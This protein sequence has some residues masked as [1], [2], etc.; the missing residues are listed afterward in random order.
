[1]CDGNFLISPHSGNPSA[2]KLSGEMFRWN[3]KSSDPFSQSLSSLLEINFKLVHQTSCAPRK[4]Q[5]NFSKSHFRRKETILSPFIIINEP[6]IATMVDISWEPSENLFN[7]RSPVSC[8]WMLRKQSRNKSTE[9]SLMFPDERNI[10]AE[11]SSFSSQLLALHL[12]D[13]L[14]ALA[15]FSPFTTSSL[16]ISNLKKKMK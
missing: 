10:H 14:Q 12:N 11:S 2:R 6:E 13:F 1:M 16:V 7:N 9:T 4:A 15:F 3:N 8:R 5:E